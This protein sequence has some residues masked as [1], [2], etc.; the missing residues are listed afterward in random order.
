VRRSIGNVSFF[1]QANGAQFAWDPRDF[2]P[3][4][5]QKYAAVYQDGERNWLKGELGYRLRVAPKVP[6][7]DFGPSLLTMCNFEHS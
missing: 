2:P 6:V 5:G 3:G 7:A 4:F 1:Y